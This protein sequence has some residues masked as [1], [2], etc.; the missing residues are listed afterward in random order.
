MNTKYRGHF[1]YIMDLDIIND[2]YFVSSNH[3]DKMK[4]IDQNLLVWDI[5]NVNL[6]KINYFRAKLNQIRFIWI[7]MSVIVLRIITKQRQN[8]MVNSA[9]IQFLLLILQLNLSNSRKK[10]LL[11]KY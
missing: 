7:F 10:Y 8:S 5:R 4:V 6:R 2:K 9:I 1:D 3:I 11:Y